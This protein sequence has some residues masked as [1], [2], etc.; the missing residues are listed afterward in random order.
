VFE[1]IFPQVEIMILERNEAAFARVRCRVRPEFV[2]GD[3][4]TDSVTQI[5]ILACR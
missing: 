2:T 1:K 3:E 5:Q 4:K